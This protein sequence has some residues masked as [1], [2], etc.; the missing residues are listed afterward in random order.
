MSKMY[1]WAVIR[2]RSYLTKYTEKVRIKTSD[3]ATVVNSVKQNW[4]KCN[5]KK[6]SLSPSINDYYK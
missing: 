1:L 6:N 2:I 4:T 5:T 3:V